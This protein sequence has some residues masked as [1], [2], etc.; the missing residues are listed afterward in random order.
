MSASDNKILQFGDLKTYNN[1]VKQYV[2]ANK[3]NSEKTT[4]ADLGITESP[5]NI[6][7]LSDILNRVYYPYTN[8]QSM[9]Y[10]R[11]ISF[12]ISS[13]SA[14]ESTYNTYIGCYGN[15]KILGYSIISTGSAVS[16]AAMFFPLGSNY[17]MVVQPIKSL[18]SD[19]YPITGTITIAYSQIQS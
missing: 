9:V 15:Y 8:G 17:Y 18:S 10:T 11:D 19:N 13:A 12:T 3:G 7:M 2:Q 14:S 16:T 1:K 4:L 6:N 5:G